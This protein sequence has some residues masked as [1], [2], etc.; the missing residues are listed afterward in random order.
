[1]L[2]ELSLEDDLLLRDI[3]PELAKLGFA[4]REFGPSTWSLEAVPAGLPHASESGLV[5]ELLDSY[6][7][8]R[9]TK[10]EP[11]EALAASFACRTAIKSGTALSPAEMNALV[12]ELFATEFP[13]TCPHGRPTLIYLTLTELDR[14]F[15]RTT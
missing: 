8:W 7:E 6:R 4:I 13:Y 1:L 9:E 10:V 12:D 2:I 11:Q 5:P 3:L 14:R 15:K